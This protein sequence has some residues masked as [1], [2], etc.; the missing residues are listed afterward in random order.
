M[1]YDQD[2][3]IAELWINPFNEK[4]PSILGEDRGDPGDTADSFALRQ[5][6][7]D[8]NEKITVDKLVVGKT[9]NDVC[10]LAK[11]PAMGN[12][13]LLAAVAGILGLG[14]VMMRR[15]AAAA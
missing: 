8:L 15:K 14:V 10:V 4:A 11:V 6:D 2:A 13:G 1:R 7:S 3:N 5:S 9:F 12:L